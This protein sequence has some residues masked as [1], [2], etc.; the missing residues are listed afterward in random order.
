MKFKGLESRAW[1]KKIDRTAGLRKPTDADFPWSPLQTHTAYYIRKKK[2]HLSQIQLDER[3]LRLIQDHSSK[4]VA[5]ASCA[6]YISPQTLRKLLGSDLKVGP[7]KASGPHEYLQAVFA[8]NHVNPEAVSEIEAQWAH[9]LCE[10]AAPGGSSRTLGQQLQRLLPLLPTQVAPDL[11]LQDEINAQVCDVCRDFATQLE[12]LRRENQWIDAHTAVGWLSAVTSSTPWES[13]LEASLLLNN[14]L[15]TWRAWAGW[16]PFIPRLWAWADFATDA[17]SSLEDLLALEGPD[18]ASTVGSEEATLRQ[19]LIT[20]SFNGHPSTIQ[21]G[22]SQVS[23]KRN[24][25]REFENPK[26]I[27]ERLTTAVDFACSAGHEYTTLLVYLCVDQV[28]SDEVLQIL[29]G[30]RILGQPKFTTVVLQAITLVNGSHGQTIKAMIE[31]L[32][33]LND[34]R[35]H[36]LRERLKEHLV[37]QISDHVRGLQN[38][39]IRE[40]DA[41]NQWSSAANELLIFTHGLREENWLLAQLSDSL[42]Q[43]IASGPPLIT[44][45]TLGII[46]DSIKCVKSSAPTSLMNCI[47]AYCKALF[48]KGE[49]VSPHVRGVVEALL[50]LW[51]QNRDESRLELALLVAD[52]PNTGG[53][54]RCDLL[55][56]LTTLSHSLVINTL[57]VLNFP[58]EHSGHEFF[59]LIGLL[60]SEDKLEVL[61]LWRLVLVN[62]IERHH[63]M[64]LHH[65]MKTLSA[66]KW[67]ELLAGIRAIYKGSWVI[68]KRDDLKL[69]SL[70]VHTWSQEMAVHLPTVMRLASVLDHGPAMEM[71]LLGPHGPENGQ[72]LRVLDCVKDSEAT[73]HGKLVNTIIP[74]LHSGN[75]D[76]VED[77]LSAVCK[78]S[79]GGAQACLS[80]LDARHHE[81]PRFAEVVLASNIRAGECSEQDRLALRGVASLFGIGLDIER[82]PSGLLEVSNTLHEQYQKLITETQ[83][84]E[85]LRLSLRAVSPEAVSKLLARLHIEASS[86]VDDTLASLPPSLGS[87]IERI[88][89]N[90]IELQFPGT[91][92]TRMQ[93][94]AIGAGDAESFL[95]RLTLGHDGVPIKFCVHLSTEFGD[96]IKSQMASN[97]KRHTG[98]ELSRGNRAPYEQFCHGRPNRGNYQLSRMLWGHLR[99]EF[100]SLELTHAHITSKVATLGQG[101]VVC[102][103]G[104]LRLRRATT[105][106]SLFC[107]KTFAQA[108]V[109][110]QLVE[111][112]EDEPV[113]DLL[114]TMIYAVAMSGSLD[115]LTNFPFNNVS[116][117]VRILDILPPISTLASHLRSCL[118][119]SGKNFRLAE[120]L[121]KVLPD[122]CSPASNS[123]LLANGLLRACTS[124][125]GFLVS[126]T[127]F[128]RIPSFGEN[129]FL[130]A[131]AAPDLEIA[132]ARHMPTSQSVSQIMFHGTSLDRLHAIICQGLRV[133][134]GTALQRHGA[135]SGPGIYMADEPS[136]AWGYATVSTGGWNSSK[137]KNM[138]VLLGCEL[139]GPKPVTRTNGIYVIT[140]A[141]RLA[142]RCIFLLESN[143]RM[144]A[145]KHMRPPMQSLFQS[146]RSGT[147]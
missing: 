77:V 4:Q 86:I 143:A 132:F 125:R 81:S 55:R 62:A 141:T 131:N 107:Q 16:R 108:H 139:A 24:P 36:L 117:V 13:N 10:Y 25:F 22:K 75:V 20:Q 67:L 92:L 137:L 80:V 109:E 5:I 97:T 47:D 96:G 43:F 93:R 15:P 146:L 147:M 119:V 6:H 116:M 51:Q 65:A 101:C 64:L 78:T 39:F 1:H 98:W 38:T 144:P 17:P 99:D 52:L 32:P 58:T 126:A 21:W 95:I 27:F 84:L 48:V 113:M 115:L 89:E 26:G 138:K 37:D 57:A 100:V 46:R 135:A 102:G 69:L 124:Y 88:S 40:L 83:R 129:Q 142:V 42:R 45:E 136:V 44:I 41:R 3:L 140:D 122:H 120:A 111:I 33:A 7:N 63:E 35:L 103:A 54:L 30:V 118:I 61:Q 60:A 31:M 127:R 74:L 8:T 23:F 28:I 112:W 18:F 2:V 66:E 114:L 128:Q 56:A 76:D 59:T 53:Q 87:L 106:P 9:C 85:S 94:L 11:F 50:E 90:E 91:N 29:E 110:I 130:L 134:S 104:Q 12:V 68:R 121:A 82:N 79:P 105:C 72:L 34:S 14:Q 145:A 19:G 71:F 70:E 133:Q 49:S 123:Q 73:Y